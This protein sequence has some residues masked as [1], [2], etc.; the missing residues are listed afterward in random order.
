MRTIKEV[1]ICKYHLCYFSEN[2]SNSRTT[3]RS[4]HWKKY[5]GWF[6]CRNTST[7]VMEPTAT[8]ETGRLVPPQFIPWW[9]TIEKDEKRQGFQ[10]FGLPNCIDPRNDNVQEIMEYTSIDANLL[11]MFNKLNGTDIKPADMDELF[12]NNDQQKAWA[13]QW[14]IKGITK[15]FINLNASGFTSKVGMDDLAKL[16]FK[17]KRCITKVKQRYPQ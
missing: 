16:I 5:F 9:I 2:L 12:G 17:M 13:R 6:A 1:V 10:R 15:K 11:G 8:W 4:K 3:T 7:T 14:L